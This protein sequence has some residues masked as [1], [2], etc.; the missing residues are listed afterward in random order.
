MKTLEPLTL[1]ADTV[2]CAA[3]ATDDI[4][5]LAPRLRVNQ[6]YPNSSRM[7]TPLDDLARI[8]QRFTTKQGGEPAGRCRHLPE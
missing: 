6:M 3:P 7:P 4:N 2:G 8:E 1:R 5:R